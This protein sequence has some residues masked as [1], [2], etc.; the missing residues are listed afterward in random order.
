MGLGEFLVSTIRRRQER[1]KL[2]QQGPIGDFWRAGGNALLT[3]N[4]PVDS[5]TT[6][7]DGGA[8]TGDWLQ[9]MAVEYGCHVEA[10]EAV[11]EY[12]S[13]LTDR[14]AR[15]SRIAIHPL[16]LGSRSGV[17]KVALARDGSTVV[18][19]RSRGTPHTVDIQVC[20]ADSEV[21][22]VAAK[23]NIGCVKLNVEGSEYE[24]LEQLAERDSLSLSASWLIQFHRVD[25]T[26]RDR[27]EALRTALGRTH[28]CRWCF[29]FVWELWVRTPTL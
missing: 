25:E 4:L 16:A 29:E 3:A 22:R 2:S 28:T 18:P 13:R 15:N 11:P 9:N 21:R 26:S 23:R 24:I 20:D 17:A 19:Q 10:Y 12:A 7:I 6:V 8:Y 14:F 27:R 1:H 5:E